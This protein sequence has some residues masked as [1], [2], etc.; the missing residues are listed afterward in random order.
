M[1]SISLSR[2]RS[3]HQ[4]PTHPNLSSVTRQRDKVDA[5]SGFIFLRNLLTISQVAHQKTKI[6]IFYVQF[7]F[8]I[9]DHIE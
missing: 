5:S 3:K 9:R 4:T 8:T 7:P 1:A 6:C 2:V